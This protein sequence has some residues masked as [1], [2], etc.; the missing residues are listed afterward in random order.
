MARLLQQN[1]APSEVMASV[2]AEDVRRGPYAPCPCRSG[3]KFRFCHGI[4]A[5]SSPFSGLDAP[6]VTA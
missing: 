3:R 6:T 1:R 5:P 2:Q 4:K